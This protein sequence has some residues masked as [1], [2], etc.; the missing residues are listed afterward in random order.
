MENSLRTYGLAG[1]FLL[2][3]SCLA[4]ADDGGLRSTFCVARDLAVVSLIEAEGEAQSVRPQLLFEATI[5][6]MQARKACQ[7]GKPDLAMTIY[8]LVAT[9]LLLN[10]T[11]EASAKATQ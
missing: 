3:A 7:S 5:E 11:T 1:L 4:R 8:D 9:E 10:E 6:V 2:L